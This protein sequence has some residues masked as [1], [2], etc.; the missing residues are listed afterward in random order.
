MSDHTPPPLTDRKTIDTGVT[1]T[2][3]AFVGALVAETARGR[4]ISDRASIQIAEQYLHHE[5]L[6]GFS[7]PRMQIRDLEVD[8]NFAVASSQRGA[9]FLEDD[10]VQKNIGYRMR[11]FLASLP[12][13]RDFNSYFRN[14]AHLVARWTSGLDEMTRRFHHVLVRPGMDSASVIHGLSLSVQNYFYELAPDDLQL[15]VSSLL[16]RPINKARGAD[17]MQTMIEREIQTI[18]TSADKSEPQE[19]PESPPNLKI[20]VGA[21]QLEKLSPNLLSKMKITVSPSDRKWVVSEK[22]GEKVYILGT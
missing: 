16:S 14:D 4:A 10:E 5:L 15:R 2:V 22:D 1:I 6:R 11:D 7:V 13:H 12:R 18:V 3:G 8:L 9:F 21:A 20:L 19:S 17:S